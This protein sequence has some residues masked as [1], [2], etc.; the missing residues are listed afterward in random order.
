MPWCVHCEKWVDKK[1]RRC[2]AC[3]QAGNCYASSK[4]EGTKNENR[5]VRPLRRR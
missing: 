4:T 3:I 2:F 1:G 5:Q